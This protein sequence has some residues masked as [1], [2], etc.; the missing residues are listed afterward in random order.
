MNL[1]VLGGACAIAL[2]VTIY[3]PMLV[4]SDGHVDHVR[5]ALLMLAMSTG[6]IRGVG[7]I[8]SHRFWRWLFSTPTALAWLLLAVW[9]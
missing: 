8:P 7:Y 6:F 9:W 1:L 4:Q 2:V 5:L 3:P